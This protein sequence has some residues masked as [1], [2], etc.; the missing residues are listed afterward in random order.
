MLKKKA[1]PSP[2]SK[3]S[4]GFTFDPNNP[5]LGTEEGTQL[6]E[7]S[8][9]RVGAGRSIVV[10]RDGVVIAGNKTLRAAD[11]VHLPV[12]V[13]D[14][15]GKELVV[16]RRKDLDYDD[17]KARE[18]A[19]ADNRIAEMNLRWDPKIIAGLADKGIA[20]SYFSARKLAELVKTIDLQPVADPNLPE[21]VPG[22]APAKASSPATVPS[23]TDEA[24]TPA[25]S[26]ATDVDDEPAAPSGIY[27][28]RED[29]IFPASNKWGL[30]DLRPDMLSDVVPRVTWGG[31]KDISN[32]K[33]MLFIYGSN[34]LPADVAGGVLAFYVDDERFE[35]VW[36][37][38]VEAVERFRP[39]NFGAV[40]AP[41]FSVWRDDPLAVQLFNIYRSRWCAR[42]WQEAGIP[43][44]PSLN[45]GDERSYEF[46]W[47]G[48]PTRPPV[49]SCQCRTTRSRKGQ[50]YFVQGLSEG[51]RRVRPRVVVMYGGQAHRHW[52]EPMLPRREATE[53]VWI[54]D[55]M[56]VRRKKRIANLALA[57][58]NRKGVA[59]A[60][61]RE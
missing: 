18:L 14:T 26:A 9:E 20:T 41:D 34:A 6:L 54:E 47:D 50:K 36:N 32:P 52:I 21:Y 22:D 60:A 3:S 42:Y 13:V 4:H 23:E 33:G 15:D 17:L 27:A 56:S 43:V 55:F 35:G 45:W 1:A 16:V 53:Y 31:D 40:I 37:D 25:A 48:M 12:R 46:A 58:A 61:G 7:Q 39:R 59:R 44:I 19:L 5:N 57:R 38:A 29:A 30:P 8:L 28:F 49:V 11:K 10:T 24:T 51:I 2:R